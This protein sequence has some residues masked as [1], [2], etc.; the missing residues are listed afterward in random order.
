MDL[1]GAPASVG[2]GGRG[3][4][5]AAVRE[6]I[7]RRCGVEVRPRTHPE[8]DSEG[9]SRCTVGHGV[10]GDGVCVGSGTAEGSAKGGVD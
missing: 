5:D 2:V 1:I 6:E 3:G 9:A 10:K 4:V 7:E 8:V